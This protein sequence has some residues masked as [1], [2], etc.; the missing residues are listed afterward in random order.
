MAMRF[1]RFNRVELLMPG[2]EVEA[3]AK[4]FGELLGVEFSPVVAEANGSVLATLSTEAGLELIGPASAQSPLAAQLDKKGRGGIGPII[5]EVDDLDDIRA[6][7]AEMGI[8]VAHEFPQPNGG[9]Q[10]MLHAD[11][12]FGYSLSFTD[13][14]YGAAEPAAGSGALISR[15][16]RVE[17]LLPADKL[18]PAWNFFSRLLDIKIDPFHYYPE[19]HVRTVLQL[20]GKFELFGP[21]DEKSGLHQVLAKYPAGGAIGPV[22]WEVPD[23]EAMRKHAEKLGHTV[24]YE[25]YDEEAGR[26]Q[27]CLSSATLFGYTL[28]FTQFV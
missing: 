27:I 10:L 18:D 6:I 26:K 1:K 17:L 19:H 13:K 21:G 15:I 24:A 8:R 28:T 5:W 12:C 16:N 2:E 23:L 14:P 4:V 11:D 9:T 7:A 25:L 22:V 3:A 20:E